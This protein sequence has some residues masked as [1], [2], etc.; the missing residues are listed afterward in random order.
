MKITDANILIVDDDL[1]VL[2]TAQLFLKQIFSLIK[3]EQRPENIPSLMQTIDFDIILLD[4]NFSKGK[5]EG[6]EG[7]L[8]LNKILSINPSSVVVFIT[9]YGGVNLAVQSMKV[10]AF[11]F[12][13]KPWKNEDLLSVIYSGL[14]FRKS[15]LEVEHLKNSQQKLTEDIDSNFKNF[16]GESLA[17]KKVFDPSFFKNY[18]RKEPQFNPCFN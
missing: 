14:Q 9:A 3:V 2:V 18:N 6:E 1:D 7:I 15:K 17:I 5:N 11:D 4:M 16:I 10:G 12:I 8:W 13:V